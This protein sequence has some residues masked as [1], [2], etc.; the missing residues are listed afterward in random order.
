MTGVADGADGLCG[1]CIRM[2]CLRQRSCMEGNVHGRGPRGESVTS[3][4]VEA[5]SRP[6]AAS[7]GSLIRLFG[8]ATARGGRHRETRS[9]VSAGAGTLTVR[10][11]T[12]GLA[13][14]RTPATAY[15]GARIGGNDAEGMLY[16]TAGSAATVFAFSSGAA[17]TVGERCM[18]TPRTAPVGL[19]YSVSSQA[20][21]Y[22]EAARDLCRAA[23]GT[24]C[25]V[26]RFHSS[27]AKLMAKSALR[28]HVQMGAARF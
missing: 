18:A 4:P 25:R 24:N 2:T 15:P 26:R 17:G 14:R 9:A 5:K 16:P 21:R 27:L 8:Q 20:T 23:L 13:N 22:A 12:E 6:G 28:A 1:L 7:A 19:G 10:Q 11:R 3:P